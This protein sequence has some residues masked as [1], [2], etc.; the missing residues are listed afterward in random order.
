MKNIDFSLARYLSVQALYQMR[1][2]EQEFENILKQYNDWNIKNIYFDFHDSYNSMNLHVNK[3]YFN[4]L[5]NQYNK[6][7]KKFS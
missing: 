6:E 1:F 5:L 2:S 7:K 3:K 4:N